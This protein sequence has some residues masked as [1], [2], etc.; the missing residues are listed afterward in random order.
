MVME[1]EFGKDAMEKF[2]KYELD[3]YL[4]GRSSERINEQP[5]ARNDGQGYIHYQ[6]GSL[7][8]YAMKDYLGEDTLNA[9]LHRFI[10]TY[11]FQSPP[12]VQAPQFVQYIADAT[13]DSLKQVV[14]DMFNRIT[15]FDLKCVEA[16]YKKKGNKYEVTL[17]VET[18]KVYADSMGNGTGVKPNDWIDIGIMKYDGNGKHSYQYLQKQLFTGGRKTIVV[19]VDEKPSKAGIDPLHKL[20]DRN[21]E[22]NIK[23]VKSLQ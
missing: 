13:P 23:E 8:M 9:A 1:K 10:K 12:Y 15:L 11:G 16:G 20:I 7:V 17:D 6:K 22:D 5:I 3:G 19:T 18:G 21:S 2:L 4:S 14:E